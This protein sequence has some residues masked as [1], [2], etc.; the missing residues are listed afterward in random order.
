[1][2]SIVTLFSHILQTQ[3]HWLVCIQ[4][5]ILACLRVVTFTKSLSWDHIS[6]TQLCQTISSAILITWYLL[7]TFELVIF[8]VIVLL[9]AII[10]YLVFLFKPHKFV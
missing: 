6:G 5:Q 3:R 4:I 8:W 2:L 1:V 10:L 9:L 7:K